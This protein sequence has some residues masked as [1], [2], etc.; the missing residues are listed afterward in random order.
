MAK[1]LLIA[2]LG[3][4]STT[5]LLAAG[6]SIIPVSGGVGAIFDLVAILT[7]IFVIGLLEG[8]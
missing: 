6:G 4:V 3:T 7:G 1:I 8:G 5:T 2:V